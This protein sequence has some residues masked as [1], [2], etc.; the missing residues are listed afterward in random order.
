MPRKPNYGF[1]RSQRTKAKAEKKAERL[2]A[3]A[4]KV[5]ARKA[6]AEGAPTDD[7][8]PKIPD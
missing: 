5:A 4:E 8:S 2:R 7:E 3:K 6:T 1:E